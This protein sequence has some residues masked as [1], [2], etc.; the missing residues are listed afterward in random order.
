[1]TSRHNYG[2]LLSGGGARAAYQVGVLK[3]ITSFLPRNQGIPFPIICGNSA[4]AINAA[5]L[6]C[7]ASCY[8]L[9]VRK[10]EWVWKNFKTEQVYGAHGIDVFGHV[11]KHY[12]NRFRSSHYQQQPGSLLNN[13]PLRH[14]IRKTLDFSRIDRNLITEHLRAVSVSTSSY[15]SHDSISFFQGNG[16]ISPWQREQRRGIPC[17]LNT[18]HLMASSAIPLVFP[19]VLLNNEFMG[20]GS[21]HQLSPLSTPIRLGADKILVIGVEQPEKKNRFNN[22]QNFPSNAEIAGHL[23]DT[24]FAD[25][26]HADWERLERVNNTLELLNDKQK[27]QTGLKQIEC[28]VI[29]PST[30]FTDMA[31]RHYHLMPKGIRALLRIIGINDHSDSSILSYLLFEKEFCRELIELGY[32]DGLSQSEK[33]REFLAI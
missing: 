10:L 19:T 26:L 22:L 7:Y 31:N 27:A 2:L 30:N 17:I 23:L 28:M 9:G 12:I 3:A 21:V 14:L 8:H 20:D 29:N 11:F 18:E 4:G 24:I 6:A 13:A 25:T 1:M 5:A 15:T 32:Q 16:E 33:L